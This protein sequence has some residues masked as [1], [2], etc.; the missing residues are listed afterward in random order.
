MEKQCSCCCQTK[1]LSSFS[2]RKDS[3][4][5]RNECK[6]CRTKKLREWK[7]KNDFDRLQ[8]IKHKEK[9]LSSVHAYRKNP[10]NKQKIRDCQNRWRAKQRKENPQYK[11]AHNLR[12]RCLSALKGRYKF[13]TTFKLV[14]CSVEQLRRHIESLWSEGMSWDNYGIGGWHIDHIKPV[15]SFNLENEEQQ[16]SAFHYTNLQPLWERENLIKGSK[17]ITL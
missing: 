13:N 16:K 6:D 9:K 10:E 11:L 7:K 14:G 17:V 2:L 8:Y 12:R 1:E 15:S 5:Y 4:R 3:G